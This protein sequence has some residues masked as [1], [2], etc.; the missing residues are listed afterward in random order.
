MSKKVNVIFE[1]Q[2][3][4]IEIIRTFQDLL[5]KYG[6]DTLSIVDNID[7]ADMKV[8]ITALDGTTDLVQ[9]CN[10][11]IAGAKRI[12]KFMKQRKR[13]QR[14]IVATSRQMIN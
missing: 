7:E 1:G 5:I 2:Y 11:T 12:R 4:D 10:Y 9:Q 13:I 6:S 8:D 14:K 3:T